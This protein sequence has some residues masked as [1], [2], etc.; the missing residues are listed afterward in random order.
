MFRYTILQRRQ[1][2]PPTRRAPYTSLTNLITMSGAS[3]TRWPGA[4]RFAVPRP[5]QAIL[6][7]STDVSQPHLLVLCLVFAIAQLGVLLAM[8]AK[9]L[10]LGDQVVCAHEREKFTKLPVTYANLDGR[11]DLM[12]LAENSSRK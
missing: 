2:S 1:D 7:S 10:L 9:L 12:G 6:Y 3:S 4:S 8:S 5:H 11:I